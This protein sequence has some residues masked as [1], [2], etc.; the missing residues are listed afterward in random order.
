MKKIACVV[1]L[2][3]LCVGIGRASLLAQS[4]AQT[5]PVTFEVTSVKPSNPSATGVLG[6]IPMLMPQGGGGL[7]ASNMPLRM[8]VRMAYGVQDFQIVGGPT[9]QTSNKFDIVAKA[10]DGTATGM[11]DLLPMLKSLLADRFKLKT[12]TE[13][14]ELPTYAL[15]VARSD[16]KL[17]PDI[18]PST[19]DCSGAAAEAQQRADALLKGGPTALAALLPKPGETW[20]CAMM[21]AINPANPAA[22][23]GLRADGQPLTILTQLLTQV[24]SRTV[25]DKTG[26]SGLYDWE[27][28]FDPQVFMQLASQMGLNVPTLGANANPFSD[29]PSLLTALQEQLGLKLDSQRGPVEVLVIDSAELPEPD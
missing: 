7:T 27:L 9:W 18:K 11:Q 10:T 6:S 24:T 13:T 22:G 5:P 21:P 26:L 19:S 2:G 3:A 1:C 12:H 15:V 4:T 14:R 20:K 17:G 23:F 16:G 8:L 29:S 28:R 25:T